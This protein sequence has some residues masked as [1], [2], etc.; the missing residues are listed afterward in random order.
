MPLIARCLLALVACS[1]A[2]ETGARDS[3]AAAS[4]TAAAILA[5]ILLFVFMGDPLRPTRR[6][7]AQVRSSLDRVLHPSCLA[8][9]VFSTVVA[10]G[11]VLVSIPVLAGASL[12]LEPQALWA[13][14]FLAVLGASMGSVAA[15]RGPRLARR[16]GALALAL[17]ALFFVLL[18]HGARGPTWACCT[19]FGRGQTGQ[20]GWSS[21]PAW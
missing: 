2:A 12:Q 14:A 13:V 19:R 11:M 5:G 9:S 4:M 7:Q 16:L 1:H 17:L 18:R 8:P 20:A 15:R 6:M 10:G 3:I 21:L